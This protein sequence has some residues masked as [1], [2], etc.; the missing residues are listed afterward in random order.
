MQ[1]QHDLQNVMKNLELNFY[2]NLFALFDRKKL[3]P[4]YI[5]RLLV[6]KME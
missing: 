2:F 5:I 1:N 6:E 4:L 3:I